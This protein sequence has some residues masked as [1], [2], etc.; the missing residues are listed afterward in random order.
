MY[1]D[2]FKHCP[3]CG[4]RLEQA[5]S[6]WRCSACKGC[7]VEERIL[8]DMVLRMRD[9]T[10]PTSLA[11]LSRTTADGV[12]ACPSCGK[13][14]AHVALEGVELDRCADHGI[15]FD[16]RELQ[17][18]LHEAGLERPPAPG[19]DIGFWSSFWSSLR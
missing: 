18:T 17:T 9:G 4:V 3:A 12:R 8:A 13:G 6:V 19:A 1:R 2:S 15:W 5:R 10:G 16:G 14:M 7:W 11:F